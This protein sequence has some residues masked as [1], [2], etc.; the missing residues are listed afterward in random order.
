MTADEDW[1]VEMRSGALA[2]GGHTAVATGFANIRNTVREVNAN[3]IVINNILAT[4]LQER[5]AIE[6]GRSYASKTS[7]G[8]R[9]LMNQVFD[10]V[11]ELQH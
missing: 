3:D 2:G 6:K 1:L 5:A 11:K 9:R 7:Y 4:K 10:N 8:D